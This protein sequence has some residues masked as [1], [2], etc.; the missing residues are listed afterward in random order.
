MASTAAAMGGCKRILTQFFFTLCGGSPVKPLG[1]LNSSPFSILSCSFISDVGRASSHGLI[2]LVLGGW[3]QPFSPF[4]SHCV[5]GLLSKPL[6]L[7]NVSP[8]SISS[9]SFI[10]DFWRTVRAFLRSALVFGSKQ[11]LCTLR[12]AR[13]PSC[14][15]SNFK[16]NIN[17]PCF[18]VLIPFIA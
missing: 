9:C 8:F 18:H 4:S 14:T 1:L 6:G 3:E 2:V 7:L 17:P 15:T 16:H 11:Q 5:V 13:D 12:H 10:I